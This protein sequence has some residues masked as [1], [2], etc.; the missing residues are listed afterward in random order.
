M[1]TT[2]IAAAAAVLTAAV[3]ASARA[4][5]GPRRSRA[6]TN[7][8]AFRLAHQNDCAAGPGTSCAGTLD[9]QLSGQ[10]LE[11]CRARHLRP[12]PDPARRRLAHPGQPVSR[13]HGPDRRHW[14]QA[15]LFRR[16]HRP[17]RR[18]GCGSKS[19]PKITWW[20]AGRG[21]HMLRALRD[22]RPLSFHG[23]GLS[24]AGADEPDAAHLAR[25]KRL[26]DDFGP[27]LVSEHLAWSR[28]GDTCFPDLLPFP[29]TLEAFAAHRAQHRHRPARA[30]PA[31]PDRESFAL[32]RARR[33]RVRRN[34]FPRPPGEAHRLPAADR[35]QQRRWSAPTISASTL[36]PISMRCRTTRSARS[37]SPATR[38]TRSMATRC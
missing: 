24:L 14:L 4:P 20:T 16:G 28:G 9:A 33:P 37:I 35:R 8:T 30:R 27:M 38:P 1:K 32:R 31:D 19:T 2:H 15:L 3:A 29:R 17:R 5:A 36:M 34:R 23:V 18:P 21:S 10:C 22:A 11:I 25:L 26:V 6:W 12:H 13:D 7:A